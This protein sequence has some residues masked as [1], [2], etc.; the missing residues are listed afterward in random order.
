MK[1]KLIIQLADIQK[2]ELRW[3]WLITENLH[4]LD[5]KFFP[6]REIILAY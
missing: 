1:V 4:R 5:G 2:L 6:H 3:L